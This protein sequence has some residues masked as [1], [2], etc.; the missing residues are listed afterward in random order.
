MIPHAGARTNP[1]IRDLDRPVKSCRTSGR[2][3]I[4]GDHQI[5]LCLR[6]NTPNNFQSFHSGLCHHTRNDPAD[7]MHFHMFIALQPIFPDHMPCHMK[8]GNC[9]RAK[10]I[11]SNLLISKA[12]H[13]D[14]LL[15][16]EIDQLPQMMCHLFRDLP[17]IIL[18][19]N[20]KIRCLNGN[21][22]PLWF[23]HGPGSV[24]RCDPHYGSPNILFLIVSFPDLYSTYF[25]V[26]RL[27][28]FRCF[29]RQVCSDSAPSSHT[30][31][32][33]FC[34]IAKTFSLL[35]AAFPVFS[36]LLFPLFPINMY[37]FPFSTQHLVFFA[38]FFGI[39]AKNILTF[40]CTYNNIYKHVS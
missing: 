31:I 6:N 26:F 3:R 1:G 27:K 2:Q 25:Y 30:L 37:H 22:G 39:F 11:R 21:I 20:G 18:I 9:T 40:L 29:Q 23:S 13:Q 5:R 7:L 33:F 28:A 14:R 17:V 38:Y 32:L 15:P 36:L 19:R 16:S 34:K 35:P 12:Y 10:G 8:I 24:F 4:Y